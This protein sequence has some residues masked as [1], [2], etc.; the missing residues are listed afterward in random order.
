[1]H[2]STTKFKIK[3]LLPLVI[4]SLIL[5]CCDAIFLLI[6]M[7]KSPD[8]MIWKI[9]NY[10]VPFLFETFKQKSLISSTTIAVCHWMLTVV[11]FLGSLTR[12]HWHFLELWWRNRNFLSWKIIFQVNDYQME[13]MSLSW[14]NHHYDLVREP[15]LFCGH[16]GYHL[17]WCQSWWQMY[18]GSSNIVS[19]N[20]VN[21]DAKIKISSF[22]VFCLWS[23]IY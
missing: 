9:L 23:R 3:F 2:L 12:N 19:L 4:Y 16:E 5:L 18:Y 17:S 22:W 7:L 13:I 14:P 1:M 15:I 8:Q 10:N 6:V 20:L 11:D 21:F